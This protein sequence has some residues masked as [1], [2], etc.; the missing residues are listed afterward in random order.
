MRETAEISDS[1]EMTLGFSLIRQ[2]PVSGLLPTMMSAQACKPLINRQTY[3]SY[4]IQF[5]QCIV[6]GPERGVIWARS[7]D[8]HRQLRVLTDVGIDTYY[9]TRESMIINIWLEKW[10]M[11]TPELSAQP[12]TDNC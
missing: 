9:Q 3:T 10:H 6:V 7:H 5:E 2:I 11:T 1:L 8:R 4:L 12:C